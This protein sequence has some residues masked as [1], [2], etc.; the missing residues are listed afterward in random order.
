MLL[1]FVGLKGGL[2]EPSEPPLATPLGKLN[3]PIMKYSWSYCLIKSSLLLEKQLLYLVFV[4]LI[5]FI[6]TNSL[7][8]CDAY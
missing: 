8:A 3:P 5:L 1:N 6:Q 7:Y 4:F 2:S